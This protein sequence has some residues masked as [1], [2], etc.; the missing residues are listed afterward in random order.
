[1]ADRFLDS[2]G[3]RHLWE[4]IK[5]LVLGKADK[6]DTPNVI[7]LDNYAHG[8]ST[9]TDEQ[10]AGLRVGDIIEVADYTGSSRN[11]YVTYRR[12]EVD[13][14]YLFNVTNSNDFRFYKLEKDGSWWGL[15]ELNG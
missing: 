5:V 9:L 11:S 14:V 4:K 10:V 2:I 7:H 15:V 1:M 8:F 6:V 3:L 12:D 13:V